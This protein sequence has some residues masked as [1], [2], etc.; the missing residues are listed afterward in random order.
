MKV[1]KYGFRNR[2][3]DSSIRQRKKLKISEDKKRGSGLLFA[4]LL[5]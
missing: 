5:K 4:I 2:A 1:G 3:F